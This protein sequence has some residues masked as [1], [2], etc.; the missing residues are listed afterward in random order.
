[1]TLGIAGVTLYL[2]LFMDPR[3]FWLAYLTNWN[4]TISTLYLVLSFVNS[5]V[6]VA[7]PPLGQTVVSRRVKWTWVLFTLSANVGLVVTI[8][9]WSLIFD[10]NMDMATL[11][12]HGILQAAVLWDGFGINAIPIRLRHYL[13]WIVP[14]SLA[15]MLWSYLHIRFD[16]GNPDTMDEDPETNDDLIYEV[17][18]W[19]A[20]EMTAVVAAVLVFGL[21]PLLHIVLWFVSG[22]RR[23]YEDNGKDVASSTTNYVEMGRGYDSKV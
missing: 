18:N 2:G 12:P 11:F 6:P 23:R 13:E 19:N 5:I 4:V 21:A 16:I 15:Y 17:L 8:A 20:P 14:F 22:C 1:M 3:P 7:G 10:G 9:Y